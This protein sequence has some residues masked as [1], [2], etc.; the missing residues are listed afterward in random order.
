MAA[1]VERN[2]LGRPDALAVLCVASMAGDG[3]A[4]LAFLHLAE[5]VQPAAQLLMSGLVIAVCVWP[6]RRSS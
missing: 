2:R 4:Y 5:W 6:R 3:A 1:G